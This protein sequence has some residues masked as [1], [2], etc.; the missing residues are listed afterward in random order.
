MLLHGER[1]AGDLAIGSQ[2][3]DGAQAEEA[4]ALEVVAGEAVDAVGA[5][6]LAPLHRAPVGRGEAAEVADVE[7][8]AQLD[9]AVE[10]GRVRGEGVRG[11]VRSG[12]HLSECTGDR[13]SVVWGKRVSVRVDTGGRRR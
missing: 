11:L 9:G 7:D 5:E 8:L 2:V 12:R 6:H 4:D 3:D 1:A 10:R 13:K